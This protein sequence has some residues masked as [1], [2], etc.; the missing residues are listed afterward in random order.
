MAASD[1]IG[2]VEY[3]WEDAV[4]DMNYCDECEEIIYGKSHLLVYYW[5]QKHMPEQRIVDLCLCPSCF[6]ES[7]E[8]YEIN[9][10]P[11]DEDEINL[12]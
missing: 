2:K 9:F 12:N 6:A 3:Y 1:I 4:S 10:N 5:W 11:W 8:D 7:S